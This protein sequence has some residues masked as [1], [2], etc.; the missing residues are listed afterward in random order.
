MLQ[1]LVA[2]PTHKEILF[3]LVEQSCVLFCFGVIRSF[4]VEN[5]S[6][7]KKKKPY[8]FVLL[9]GDVCQKSDGSSP[10]RY[11]RRP[12]VCPTLERDIRHQNY[13]QICE[14]IG[15]I[16]VVCCSPEV[17]NDDD[18]ISYSSTKQPAV[19]SYSAAESTRCAYRTRQQK[20][21]I[22]SVW[23]YPDELSRFVLDWLYT[24]VD[25]FWKFI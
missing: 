4:L 12:E 22:C 16:P 23:I 2:P 8:V 20:T 1:V 7:E 17:K 5:N 11:C 9:L 25:K 19:S 24:C 14:F 18:Q 13:P 21:S 6:Y 15:K 3:I 10:D